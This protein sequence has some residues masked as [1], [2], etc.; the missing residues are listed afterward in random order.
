MKYWVG[1][2]IENHGAAILRGNTVRVGGILR[3]RSREL[4]SWHAW[5]C[6]VYY[7]LAFSLDKVEKSLSPS[8][9]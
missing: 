1:V 4:F 2:V 6:S 9:W 7:I 5:S 3:T 8:A